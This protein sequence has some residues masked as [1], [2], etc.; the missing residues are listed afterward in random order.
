MF[1]T[2][3]LSIWYILLLGESVSASSNYTNATCEDTLN[4]IEQ[5]ST[6]LSLSSQYNSFGGDLSLPIPPHVKEGD[7]LLLFLSRTDNVLPL[8][9]PNGWTTGPSCFKEDNK[10]NHLRQC[11]TAQDCLESTTTFGGV[12]YCTRFPHNDTGKDLA[13]V[14]FY[15][16][17]SRD[18]VFRKNRI[19]W[20]IPGYTPAWATLAA[21]SG[22]NMTHPI[23]SWGGTSCDKKA[24][25]VFPRVFGEPGDV[26]LLSMANDDAADRIA[27]QAPMGTEI[28]QEQHGSDEAGFLYAQRLTTSGV[29]TSYSTQGNGTQWWCKDLLL[30]VVIQMLPSN[31]TENKLLIL[32]KQSDPCSDA[33]GAVTLVD[34]LSWFMDLYPRIQLKLTKL[35]DYFTQPTISENGREQLLELLSLVNESIPT[36]LSESISNSLSPPSLRTEGIN[37]GS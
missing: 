14:V 11:W 22:A 21:I 28:V 29:T 15:K 3:I 7:L 30:S 32:D 34:I 5:G 9:L 31:D 12:K 33:S 1:T 20:N 26:L 19:N 8:E 6:K 16:P 37:Y 13:T 10:G 17:Y 35:V 24:T 4:R 23:R 18:G 36:S 2:C 27:F 25:S